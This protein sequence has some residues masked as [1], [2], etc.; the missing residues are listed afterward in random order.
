MGAAIEKAKAHF[1]QIVEEQLKRVE[2][3]FSPAEI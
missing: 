1:G 2:E 3:W